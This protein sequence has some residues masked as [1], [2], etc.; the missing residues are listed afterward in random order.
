MQ[1][2]AKHLLKISI[3]LMMK[4][5]QF[6]IDIHR[7]VCKVFTEFKHPH[8]EPKKMPRSSLCPP[9]STTLLHSLEIKRH[10]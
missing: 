4:E 6:D 5:I 7:L 3:K 10:S 9:E 8:P 1:F 2:V